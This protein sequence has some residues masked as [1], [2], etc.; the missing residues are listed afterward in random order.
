MGGWG[1]MRMRLLFSV[2]CVHLVLVGEGGGVQMTMLLM[3]LK[4]QSSL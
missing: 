1:V 2:S 4:P 3:L